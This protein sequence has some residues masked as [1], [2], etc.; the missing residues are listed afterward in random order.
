MSTGRKLLF[1]LVVLFAVLAAPELAVRLS[2]YAPSASAIDVESTN[3]TFYVEDRTGAHGDWFLI[4]D[5]VARSNPG[6][7]PQ[8]FHDY[9]IPVDPGG[10]VRLFAFGGSTTHGVPFTQRERGFPERLEGLLRQRGQDIEVINV[11]VAGMS[12]ASFPELAREA[13]GLGAAGFVIYS[14]NNEYMRWADSGC[15]GGAR[16]VV[17]RLFN[18]S[19]A[20]L[21]ARSW[22]RA[23]R[24]PAV[25]SAD[26]ILI[27]QEACTRGRALEADRDAVMD[28]VVSAYRANLTETLEIA[29][30]AGLP[31]W[32]AKPAVNLQEP[33][34]L[35]MPEA[36]DADAQFA[37]GMAKLKA[38]D[39]EGAREALEQALDRDALPLRPPRSLRAVIPPLCEAREAVTC[40][41]VE[42]AF[43]DAS[44]GLPGYD[45][46]VDFCHPTFE[47]GVSLIAESFAAE[48]VGVSLI[49]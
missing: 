15:H 25:M 31:V 19:Y 4:D 39:V 32:L 23:F 33:P 29:A 17:E 20:F 13:V 14:G 7:V 35:S 44:E 46:F 43:L 49:R 2:G 24:P 18:S 41:D 28:A 10:K 37:A 9:T 30:A 36:G 22:Y 11:G 48:M 21:Y 47:E 26:A 45:L 5:G 1:S 8:G 3:R 38:R 42:Q 12:S 16:T 40:V 6:L 34:N 27:H